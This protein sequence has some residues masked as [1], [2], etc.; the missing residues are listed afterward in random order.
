MGGLKKKKREGRNTGREERGLPSLRNKHPIASPPQQEGAFVW[1]NPEWKAPCLQR[2][3]ELG[4]QPAGGGANCFRRAS[5]RLSPGALTPGSE[6]A[7]ES[8]TRAREPSTCRRSGCS[9]GLPRAEARHPAAGKTGDGTGSEGRTVQVSFTCRSSAAFTWGLDLSFLLF[10]LN[11]Q[12][13]LKVSSRG[14]S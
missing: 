9:H 3:S 4:R 10:T 13:V 5:T 8:R 12:G 14:S 6:V 1:A 7:E 2:P 11:F